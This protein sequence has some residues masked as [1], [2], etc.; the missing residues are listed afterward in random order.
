LARLIFIQILGNEVTYQ[1]RF[2]QIIS[3]EIFQ[4]KKMVKAAKL[5]L[6][7]YFLLLLLSS[8]SLFNEIEIFFEALTLT[9]S[10]AC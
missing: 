1:K 8:S 10:T 4:I 6:F 2:N 9:F 3:G 7:F 5:A